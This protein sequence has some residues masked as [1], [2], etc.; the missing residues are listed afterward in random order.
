MSSPAAIDSHELRVVVMTYERADLLLNL[1][2][3]IRQFLPGCSLRVM[4]DGSSSEAQ[5]RL[6]SRLAGECEVVVRER[7]LS[8]S[9]GGLYESMNDAVEQ[10]RREGREWVLFLQDDLQVVQPAQVRWLPVQ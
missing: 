8:G 4:D 2:A 9:L 3:S 1:V 10:A 6:L 5:R 7:S